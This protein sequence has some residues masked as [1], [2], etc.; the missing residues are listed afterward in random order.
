M[1]NGNCA[2]FTYHQ[3]WNGKWRT[4]VVSGT[5]GKV[6]KIRYLEESKTRQKNQLNRRSNTL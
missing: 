3:R 6:D 4:R 2:Y 5:A 1:V